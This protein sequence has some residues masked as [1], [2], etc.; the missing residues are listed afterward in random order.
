MPAV[1]GKLEPKRV[2]LAWP[3]KKETLPT[4]TP[5]D[6]LTGC[7]ALSFAGDEWIEED[8]SVEVFCALACIAKLNHNKAINHKQSWSFNEL[9]RWL[10]LKRFKWNMVTYVKGMN[11]KL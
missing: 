8:A 7:V 11:S 2:T 3:I 1:M 4:A 10:V 5:E 6:E 9:S